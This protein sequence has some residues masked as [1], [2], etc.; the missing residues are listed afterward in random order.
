[1]DFFFYKKHIPVL[2]TRVSDFN[3][4]VFFSHGTSDS[5]GALIAYLGKTSFALNKQKKNKAGR[6]LILHVTLDTDQYILINLYNVNIK[7][8]QLKILKKLQS[9]L[10]FFDINQQM[11]YICR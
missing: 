11:D 6:I 9:L 10:K 3:G 7:T 5:C 4:W 8:E 2:N 1:M